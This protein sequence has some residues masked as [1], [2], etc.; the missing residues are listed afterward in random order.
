MIIY[1]SILISFSLTHLYQESLS[2]SNNNL[3]NNN[4]NTVSSITNL[5][6]S[7]IPKII[8]YSIY[9][10]KDRG[11]QIQYPSEW[12]FIENSKSH[13]I[14]SFK[15]INE[16]IQVHVMTIPQDE[17]KLLKESKENDDYYTLLAYYRNSTTTLASQ[18]A[19]KVIYLTTH[20][21]SMV[22]NAFENTTLASKVLKIATFIEPKKTYYAI[23][24]FAPPNIFSYYLP[25][26]EQMIKSFQIH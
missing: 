11:F 17:Y 15:P 8:N 7:I 5:S 23:A 1:I 18:P 14:A 6:N 16:D 26:I 4:N 13:T 2:Q 22:E 3:N 21:S 25:I 20:N 10:D 9:E 24:Y 19:L 12:E